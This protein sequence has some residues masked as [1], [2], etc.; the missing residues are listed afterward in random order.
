MKAFKICSPLLSCSPV[1]SLFRAMSPTCQLEFGFLYMA[2]LYLVIQLDFQCFEAFLKY[3][4]PTGQRTYRAKLFSLFTN[5]F[6]KT[7]NN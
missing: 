4:H 3:A 1:T 6:D 5:Q 2:F 7:A